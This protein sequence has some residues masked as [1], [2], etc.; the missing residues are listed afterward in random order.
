MEARELRELLPEELEQKLEELREELWK[1]KLRAAVKK[2]LENPA[3]IRSL[4]R[5]IARVETVKRE[6]L[7]GKG[8]GGS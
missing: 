2:T 7:R 5:D 6:L 1:L 4:R 3:R 8:A